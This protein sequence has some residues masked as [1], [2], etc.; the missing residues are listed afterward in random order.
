M[1]FAGSPRA[2]RPCTLSKIVSTQSRTGRGK[3]ES[4][5]ES[6]S[7]C[8]QCSN[9]AGSVFEANPTLYFPAQILLDAGNPH[10]LEFFRTLDLRRVYYAVS[11]VL[12]GWLH[13]QYPSTN[14]LSAALFHQTRAISLIRQRLSDAQHDDETYLILLCVLQTD[15]RARDG[16]RYDPWNS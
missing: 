16:T 10:A 11:S 15:V 1:S 6:F 4:P 5:H 2:Y 13:L 3:R 7:F 12:L 14:P 9:H 8:L